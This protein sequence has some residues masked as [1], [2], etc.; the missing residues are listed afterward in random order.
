MMSAYPV[1]DNT[2]EESTVSRKISRHQIDRLKLNI[3]GYRLY[4]NL[5]GQNDLFSEIQPM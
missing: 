5:K 4:I 1:Y 3:N 2:F